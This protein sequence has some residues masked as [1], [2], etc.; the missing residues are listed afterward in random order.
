L[1]A[2]AAPPEADRHFPG[3]ALGEVRAAR[4][5]D[6]HAISLLFAG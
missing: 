4:R 2:A 6:L 5:P 3:A 1:R